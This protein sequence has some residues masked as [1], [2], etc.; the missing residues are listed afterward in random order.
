MVTTRAAF[1]P[2]D[3]PA[4]AAPLLRRGGLAIAYTKARAGA[5]EASAGDL[6]EAP[7]SHPY[8][9]GHRGVS[10]ALMAWRRR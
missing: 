7:R 9:I 1:G 8:R 6:F 5:P 4:V 3:F 10:F 2:D